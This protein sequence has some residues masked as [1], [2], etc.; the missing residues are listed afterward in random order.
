MAIRDTIPGG[1][2]LDA[3]GNPHDAEGRSIPRRPDLEGMALPAPSSAG[4]VAPPEAVAPEALPPEAVAPPE[5]PE[6][7]EVPPAIALVEVD[8]PPPRKRRAR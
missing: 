3:K 6:P 1:Y 7:V 8:T 5:P 4:P 2:Y